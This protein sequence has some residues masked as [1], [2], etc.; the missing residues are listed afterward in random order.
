MRTKA[1]G[2]TLI[3]L[4]VVI[5][6]IAILA[7]ILVPAVTRALERG[8]QAMCTSNLHQIGVAMALY[9]NDHN[10]LWPSPTKIDYAGES[11]WMWSKQLGSYLPQRGNLDTSKEHEVFVCPSASYILRDGADKPSRTYTAT[12]ALFG[13]DPATGRLD[14]ET[15]RDSI[16][17]HSPSSTYLAGEGKQQSDSNACDSSTR[18]NTFKFDIALARGDPEN[19]RKMDYR[20]NEV[21]STLM[22]DS[23]CRALKFQDAP[24]VTQA[25]WQGWNIP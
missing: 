5:A 9:A 17:I 21:M 13:Q 2:F 4:L 16:T 11:D 8:R 3:E 14:N 24:E 7:A 12:E 18:W 20:H 22:A 23:S 10:G 15:P 1:G 25:Q 19:T 6:I